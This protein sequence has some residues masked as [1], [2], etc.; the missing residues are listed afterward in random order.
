MTLT[1]GSAVDQLA[2][3]ASTAFQS[4]HPTLAAPP[5]DH[6]VLI[7]GVAVGEGAVITD[8]YMRELTGTDEEALAKIP[9]DKFGRLLNE[10]AL[11]GTERIGDLAVDATLLDRLSIVDRDVLLLEVGIATWGNTR[12]VRATCPRCGADNDVTI[13]LRSDVDVDRS[14][15]E[16]TVTLRK[17]EVV[18]LRPPTVADET[19]MSADDKLNVAERNTILIQRC[20]QSVGGR[21]IEHAYWARHLGAGDRSR[22]LK[23]LDRKSGVSFDDLPTE[24]ATCGEK[25][26]L[27][28]DVMM[29]FRG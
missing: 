26:N 24:C 6:V 17:G 11:R 1:T 5:S 2:V 3:A 13:D 14:P 22:I 9:G 21:K 8:A 28:F 20:C 4:E 23:A 27:P 16:S 29:L 12:Q 10:I 7:D 15:F 19:A 25:S 18:V